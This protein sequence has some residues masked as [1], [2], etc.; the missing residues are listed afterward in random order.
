LD[1]YIELVILDKSF[2]IDLHFVIRNSPSPRPSPLRARLR[3]GRAHAPEGGSSGPEAARGEGVIGAI[4]QLRS[5]PLMG[6]GEG[7]GDII[8]K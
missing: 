2:R 6:E 4:H 5:S 1:A 7:G 3:P 8:F